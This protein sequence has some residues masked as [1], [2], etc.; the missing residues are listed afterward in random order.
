MVRLAAVEDLQP[1][2]P[3]IAVGRVTEAF[4]EPLP[5]DEIEAWEGD[6]S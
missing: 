1:R 2:R 5:P 3:G 6:R 4:F